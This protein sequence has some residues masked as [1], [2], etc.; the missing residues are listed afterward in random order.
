MD[1]EYGN[2]EGVRY[3][4]ADH[5]SLMKVAPLEGIP[6]LNEPFRNLYEKLHSLRSTKKTDPKRDADNVL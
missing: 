1:D 6:P 2:Q 5:F 3:L 4:S